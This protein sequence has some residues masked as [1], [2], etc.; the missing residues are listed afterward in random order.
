[1]INKTVF[2]KK[3][4]EFATTYVF[5]KALDQTGQSIIKRLKSCDLSECAYSVLSA[6]WSEFCAAHIIECDTDSI[7]DSF[8]RLYDSSIT[9]LNNTDQLKEILE[10]ATGLSI[11]NDDAKEWMNIVCKHI[12]KPEYEPLYKAIML[13]HIID[14]D[15][16]ID[17]KPW[18]KEHLVDNY[19]ELPIAEEEIME[20]VF[21]DIETDLID[22]CW[23]NTRQLIIE[24]L[25]NSFEHGRATHCK[26]R[27]TENTII[28]KN[29]G[30]EFDPTTLSYSG[31][32]LTGGSWTIDDFKKRFPE[33]PLLYEHN[34][35]YNIVSIVFPDSVFHV[36]Y[37]CE[38]DIPKPFQRQSFEIHPKYINS[39]ARYYYI[40]FSKNDYGK[41]CYVM[42]GI[43]ISINDLKRFCI[44]NESEIFLYVPNKGDVVYD[45]LHEKL[46]ICI[47]YEDAASKLHIVRE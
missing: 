46:K 19:F 21:N 17:E 36:N 5:E 6:S 13:Q 8:V 27:I 35:G 26:L 16:Q 37:L 9:A 44:S 18:L 40:D 30:I 33:I 20:A 41:I 32:N 15:H 31:E 29:D 38:I 28:I 43:R 14:E 34:S 1:M 11:S 2:Y 4:I 3:L 47:D 22:V 7:V 24:L 25:L 42:S 10:N 12:I 45:D 39:R 23:L